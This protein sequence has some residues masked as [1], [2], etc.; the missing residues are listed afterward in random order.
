MKK[1]QRLSLNGLKETCLLLDDTTKMS[2]LGGGDKVNIKGGTLENMQNGVQ[3][4]GTDG[5]TCF[6]EGVNYAI[7]GIVWK[8]SAYQ[9]LGT[10]R[11]SKSWI[12][13]GFS[14]ESFAHEYGH[15]LQQKDMSVWDYTILAVKS[16]YSSIS[17]GHS[18]KS[19]EQDASGRGS[20]YYNKN[21]HVPK[22]SNN[23]K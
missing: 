1:I 8:D 12:E 5:T 14:V 3:Y 7:G 11:I 6:F 20:D 4:V 9:L 18:S 10:I 15:Y 22:S 2:I 21:K 13:D 16:L 23:G 19:Y 17:D